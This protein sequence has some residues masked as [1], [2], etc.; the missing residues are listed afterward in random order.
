MC[1]KRI[2]STNDWRRQGQEDYLK[3]K[4]LIKRIYNSY[5]EGWDH[6]HCEFCGDK[7]STDESDL[8]IGYSIL[9]GYHWICETCFLD[10]RNEFNWEI[11]QEVDNDLT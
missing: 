9:N 5:R 7:F 10:F 8:H 11:K 2:V 4:A 1:K 6:D 3:N